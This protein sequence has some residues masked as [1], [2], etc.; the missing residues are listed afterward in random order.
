[1]VCNK[2]D[3]NKQKV[4]IMGM[5]TFAF[6]LLALLREYHIR[7]TLQMH[8]CL[9]C[10][11]SAPGVLCRCITGIDVRAPYIRF[12]SADALQTLLWGCGISFFLP[13]LPVDRSRSLIQITVRIYLLLWKCLAKMSSVLFPLFRVIIFFLQI[14]ICKRSEGRLGYLDIPRL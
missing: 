2:L 8:N 12:Y 10:E 7:F 9:C 3:N 6:L 13:Y 1:M 11:S 14:S 4:E 5:L